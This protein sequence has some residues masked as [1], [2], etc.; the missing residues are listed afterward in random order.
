MSLC[1]RGHLPRNSLPSRFARLVQGTKVANYRLP[2]QLQRR[3]ELSQEW[4]PSIPSF[5]TIIRET[6]LLR[7]GLIMNKL[8]PRAR[9]R[10]F[11]LPR[12]G[13]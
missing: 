6:Q 1:R 10:A 5:S 9:V 2:E 8:A 11:R 3:P 7:S 12:I 4:I 13:A